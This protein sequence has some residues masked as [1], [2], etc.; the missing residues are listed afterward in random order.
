MSAVTPEPLV[1][2]AAPVTRPRSS[3]RATPAVS[4][5]LSS[6]NNRSKLLFSAASPTPSQIRSRALL[7][8]EVASNPAGAVGGPLFATSLS[9]TAHSRAASDPSTLFTK[10][11]TAV[12]P[13]RSSAACCMA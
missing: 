12:I 10:L 1:S 2:S 7:V 8:V 11:S 3:M 5:L 13:T 4:R 9:T 6:V